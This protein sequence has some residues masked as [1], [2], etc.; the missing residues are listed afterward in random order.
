MQAL[1]CK[2]NNTLP[3]GSKRSK[4]WRHAKTR[5]KRLKIGK[6]PIHPNKSIYSMCFWIQQKFVR[7]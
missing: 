5:M 4:G 3:K 2:D 6:M 7:R 1:Q